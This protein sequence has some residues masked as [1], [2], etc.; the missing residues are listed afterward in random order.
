M[1]ISSYLAGRSQY[2]KLSNHWWWDV[3]L[4][5]LKVLYCAPSFSL[6]MCQRLLTLSQDMA[7]VS[8]NLRLHATIRYNN[9]N[10][11]GFGSTSTLL[12]SSLV[13][14][15]RPAPNPDKS[16][17]LVFSTSS[18]LRVRLLDSLWWR[19]LSSICRLHWKW[20]P[21]VSSLTVGWRSNSSYM[22]CAEPATTISGLCD[23][24]DIGCR[25]MLL[26]LWHAASSW[27]YRIFYFTLSQ[28][29]SSFVFHMSLCFSE[30]RLN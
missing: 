4:A 7:S 15:K 3:T 8:T 17:V 30:E 1:L 14:A 22:R 25:R 2:V 28:L 26:K 21:S 6:C 11:H 5:F 19:W 9:F 24:Y 18:S 27:Y 10:K 13:P 23:T 29:I 20:N 12:R 16:E